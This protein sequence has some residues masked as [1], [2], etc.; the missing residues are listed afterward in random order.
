MKMGSR[1]V[2]GAAALALVAL[3]AAPISASAV[4][5]RGVAG[6]PQVIAARSAVVAAK[7]SAKTAR[8]AARLQ[9]L[10]ARIATVLARR[11]AGFDMVVARISARIDKTRTLAGTVASAGGDVS[12]VLERLDVAGSDLAAAKAAEATA[13]DLFKAVPDATDKKA[14]FAAAKAQAHTA[15]IQLIEARSNLRN[16][17]QALKV[18]VNGL[19]TI[20]P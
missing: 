9:V 2:K 12:A 14:A 17:I 20:T 13:V 3:V 10:R 4:P 1:I 11:A 7:Q 5:G 16:A 19:Q 18:V 6:T 8:Q 15:R